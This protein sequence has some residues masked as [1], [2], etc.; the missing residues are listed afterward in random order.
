MDGKVGSVPEGHLTE[1]DLL[2]NEQKTTNSYEIMRRPNAKK[3]YQTDRRY[4][5][6]DASEVCNYMFFFQKKLF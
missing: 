2:T 3:V 5:A 1:D 6:R 4:T